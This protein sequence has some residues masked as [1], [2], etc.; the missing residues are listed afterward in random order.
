MH[1]NQP[2]GGQWRPVAGPN[3]WARCGPR[4]PRSALAAS[5]ASHRDAPVEQ[6][7]GASSST[8]CAV[9]YEVSRRHQTRLHRGASSGT[10]FQ[11]PRSSSLQALRLPG[12]HCEVQLEMTVTHTA[13]DA[14]SPRLHHVT[15]AAYGWPTAGAAIVARRRAARRRSP[16]T[17]DPGHYFCPRSLRVLFSSSHRS[18]QPIAVERRT[19]P[20]QTVTVITWGT[21]PRGEAGRGVAGLRG[22]RRCDTL[23]WGAGRGHCGPRGVEGGLIGPVGVI[24]VWGG[25][26][27]WHTAA[28]SQYTLRCLR[29]TKARSPFRFE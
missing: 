17:I 19:T 15:F 25:A 26:S 28:V 6:S 2:H 7:P 1:R 16:S 5:R 4:I 24:V 21:L 3:C 12:L 9:S 22:H 13:L 18:L 23:P 27:G 11:A 29:A 10:A 14:A 8:P 20:F